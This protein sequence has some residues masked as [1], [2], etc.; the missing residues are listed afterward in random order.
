[1]W[2]VSR[3]FGKFQD[4]LETYQMVRKVSRRTEKFPDRLE[5]L[6]L[7]RKVSRESGN[8]LDSMETFRT[9]QKVSELSGNFLDKYF[10]VGSIAATSISCTFVRRV[11]ALGVYVATAIYA[12]LA[13]ICRK[14]NLRTFGAH[15]LQKRFTHSV[16]KVQQYS[17]TSLRLLYNIVTHI[18][19]PTTLKYFQ[20][21][22]FGGMAR[23][24]ELHV[25]FLKTS[26]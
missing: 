17:S 2:K 7:V 20:H 9:V 1:M 5:S 8:F 15:M 14:S 6:Q 23:I 26:D 24:I 16:R 10:I 4:S 18:F 11:L 3:L 22:A 13:Q 25:I 19:T 12:L 21:S